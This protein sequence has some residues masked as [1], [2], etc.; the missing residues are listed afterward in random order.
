MKKSF[1]LILGL[2]LGVIYSQSAF[3]E[4]TTYTGAFAPSPTA[5]WTDT[6]CNFD[7]QNTVY[8]NTTL[9]VTS[10]I[11]TNTTWTSGNV[12]YI[13]DALIYVKPPAV[14]TI[15]PG[16]IIRGSGKA[17]LI[18]ERGA[19]II[20][21]G[22]PTQPIIFTSNAA[23]GARNYGNWGGVVICGA[24]QHN[25]VAGTN[26]IVEGGIGDAATSTGVHG[27]S[28][29]DDSSGVFSY[30]RIEFPGI[31]LTALPNSEI[32]GLSLYSVGRKTKID[33]IQVSYSG[34]D[35]FEWFGGAVDSKYLVAFRGWD[36]DLDCDNGFRGRTQF[37][38]VVRDSSIADA[39]GSN[40]FEVDNDAAGSTRQPKTKAVFSNVTIVGPSI[41]NTSSINAN[42]RR[43]LHLR[44]NSAISIFNSIFMGYRDGLL[45]DARRTVQ[46]YCQDTSFFRHNIMGGINTD[47]RLATSPVS[48]TLCMTSASAVGAFYL[49]STNDNDTI[50]TTSGVQLVNPFN[51]LNPDAR[52]TGASP[53]SGGGTFTNSLLLPLAVPANASFTNTSVGNEVCAGGSI[54]FNGVAGQPGASYSWTIPGGSPS[55]S[56]T[57]SQSATFNTPGTYVVE[58]TVTNILGSVT[59]NV[60]ITVNPNPATPVITQSGS[61]LSTTLYTS[62]QWQLGGSNISGATSQT[63]DA[64]TIEGN[65]TVIVTNSD[66]CSA[67]SAPFSFTAG[68]AAFTSSGT[69]VC[70]GD[71]I[72][73]SATTVG[74]TSYSWVFTGGNISSAST[75]TA[76]VIYNT[77][78]SFATLLTVVTPGGTDNSS[79]T[80]TVNPNPTPVVTLSGA[81]LT[82]TTFASYQWLLNGSPISGAT[83]STYTPTV[84]GDYS[85]EVTTAAGCT[86]TSS[87]TSYYVSV[88]EENAFTSINMFPNPTFDYVYLQFNSNFE[89]ELN[90]NLYDLSGKLIQSKSN[91]NFVNGYNLVEFNVND[92]KSGM[93]IVSIQNK[94]QVYTT[95]LIKQ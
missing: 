46:N 60:T 29:D 54:T 94:N 38:L 8:P 81:D 61:V 17:T 89:G 67:T 27:G 70:A 26:A 14:L 93:Y 48:D 77:A 37:V 28:N 1:L 9:T 69:S 15:E 57:A 5:R 92:L 4:S 21:Q 20:A 10:N 49:T 82:T 6:W 55:T 31:S 87:A 75:S 71:T 53:A 3:F 79:A 85:V 86:G 64:D 63:H 45:M 76:T 34:D 39:S 65:Y 41:T 62:Y 91:V 35:S 44:R 16:T 7:P 90:V 22:T 74:A 59:S 30:V 95:R 2:I 50:N 51:Y 73:Y 25:I 40:G 12:Y 13:N 18:I 32:N 66:G 24:A 68:I 88:E 47:W 11:T 33:H 42:Y 83:S 56:T 23:A 84:N 78:G 43:A 52:P 58:L 36:D 72:V 80:V 19:K